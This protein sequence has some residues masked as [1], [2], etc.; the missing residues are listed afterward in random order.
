LANELGIAGDVLNDGEGVLIRAWAPQGRLDELC[1]R[2][3]TELPPLA[4]VDSLERRRLRGD[5]VTDGFRIIASA[6]TR[7]STGVVADAATCAACAGEIRDPEDRR[8]RYPFT[9]CTHCGPRLSI[10][11]GIPYDRSNTS[12]E[13][14]PMCEDCRRE[15]E[16]PSDRRFHAQPNACPACGPRAWLE[17]RQGRRVDPAA[18]DAVDAIAATSR[19][20]KQGKI[21][22]IKGIGGFHLA[23]DACNPGSVAEL[24]RRKRRFAKPFALMARDLGVMGRYCAVGE[25]EAALLEAPAAPVV[26]MEIRG[27]AQVAEDVAPGQATLGFMLPYSPIHHL[28]LQDWDRPLV[29]TSGNVS[30]EPQC[31]DNREAG[32][33]L[34]GLADFYLLHDRDIVNRLD[35][36][37][38]RVMD[39]SPR[40][41]RRARG[42]APAPLR[43]PPGLEDSPPVLALGGE[44]KNTLCLLQDGRAVLSQHLGDLEEASTA[45]EYE[46]TLGLYG[47]L[48]QHE[49]ACLAVDLHPDYRSSQLG[50]ELAARRGLPLIEVQHHFA[51]IASVMADN[52]WPYGGG[53]VLGIALDGLGYGDEGTIWGGEFLIADYDGYERLGHLKQVRLAGGVKALLE[54]WRN[55]FAQIESLWGWNAFL[56]RFPGL[57]LTAFLQQKPVEV[58][59][60]MIRKGI[61]SPLSSSSGRLFDAVA[62]AVG[63]CPESI[64]YEGQAAVELE[65]LAGR[66]PAGKVGGYPFGSRS[67]G[68]R[69]I[70]DPGPMW[71][72]LLEDLA[73]GV[74]TE[75]LAAR[76]HEGFAAAITEL[77]CGLADREGLDTAALSGGVFQNKTLLEGVSSRLRRGGLRVLFHRR[78]PP[79]DGGLALGQAVV[80]GAAQCR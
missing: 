68:G 5:P 4:R 63:L 11:R 52:G 35:D 75:L 38:V 37:V 19:L 72:G 49:P 58:L 66:C 73:R 10:V 78:V 36:S 9:N 14:F 77:A 40:L 56:A 34:S 50:R 2:L 28:L 31:I 45:A 15:Y 74:E 13:A 67:Q 51:H 54:P 6:V 39:G 7:V 24:R 29:M 79:N 22:A 64:S 21:L 18:L 46:R 57:P 33:R 41:L 69:I 53:K 80:A 55:T 62:A 27:E 61:N 48:F 23:C 70:L 47:D 20:L 65:V 26:L 60:T 25:T 3:E 71:A 8:Y 30:E 12:M 17:D 44:L 1:R 16:D 43:L 32:R 59:R 42:Y 76:F